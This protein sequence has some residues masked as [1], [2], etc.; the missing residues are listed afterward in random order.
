MTPTNTPTDPPRRAWRRW[1][2]VTGLWLLWTVLW[3]S[4]SPVVLVGGAVVAA[5]VVL[6]F[7][8]PPVTH[9]LA[10]R[11]LWAVALAGHLMVDLVGS[12]LV[13]AREALLRG[14][15][16][17][18]AVLE[19]PLRVDT[20]LLITA[21]AHLTTL[22][23]GS[24]VL[25]VDRGGRRFYIHSLPVRNAAEAEAQRGDVAAAERWVVRALSTTAAREDLPRRA[26]RYGG[27]Q[28]GDQGEGRR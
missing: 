22:T 21:T 13:V 14:P 15:R 9:R 27:Q 8:L 1:P 25:E 10:A 18:A 17:R 7:P 5:L 2:V 24:M 12:A 3:G 16:V 19:A 6:L 11:P 20:D 23:P 26:R 28:D 4:V